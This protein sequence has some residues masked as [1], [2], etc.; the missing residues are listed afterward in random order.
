M[1][2]TPMTMAHLPEALRDHLDGVAANFATHLAREV[3]HRRYPAP[4]LVEQVLALKLA[5]KMIAK[6]WEGQPENEMLEWAM[7]ELG[8]AVVE[9]RENRDLRKIASGQ[10]Q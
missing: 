1:A 7:Q 6:R 8:I 4:G 2:K 5:A 9:E 10:V 3:Y